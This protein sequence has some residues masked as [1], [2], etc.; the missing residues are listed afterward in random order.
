VLTAALVIVCF[1]L[2]LYSYLF[3]PIVLSIWASLA[4]MSAD[5]RYVAGKEDRRARATNPLPSVAIL[6]AARDEEGCIR[7]RLVNLLSLDYPADRLHVYV[8]SDGSSDGT[9][10]IIAAFD[11]DRVTAVAFPINRG[12][13][14]V[15]NDLAER[16]TADVVV[17][18]DANTLFRPDALLRLVAPFTDPGVGG[19]CGELRLKKSAGANEDGAYWR[20]EQFLKFQEA[21]IGALLGA[22]GAIYAIRRDAWQPLAVDT[23][24]DDFTIAMRIPATGR[25]LVYQPDAIAEELSPPNIRD[26]YRRR[27]RI[28]IGNFQCLWRYPEYVASTSLATCF[29]YVSHKVLRWITPHLLL[30]GLI[31]SALLGLES[32]GWRAFALL[33]C[34]G[35][36]AAGLV[37]AL[38]SRSAKLPSVFRLAAFFVAL[39][40]AF[41]VASFRY[42]TGRYSGGWQRTSR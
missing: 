37:C 5:L 4:R 38:E 32:A 40:W 18:S 3:Y 41:L 15:L 20:Y 19:V 34:A 42:A 14:S 12:K 11:D 33:Q 8:G 1:A 35:Y 24:C 22:N 9:A 36:L 6:I 16:V 21:R 23:I 28:G 17:F 29:A 31:G 7:D 2:V 26:E 27:V 30:V 39:N 13:A 10:D 25:R